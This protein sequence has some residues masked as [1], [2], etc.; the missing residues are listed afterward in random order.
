MVFACLMSRFPFIH[1]RHAKVNM[2][3]RAPE[4]PITGTRPELP[5]SRGKVFIVSP[6]CDAQEEFGAL[7]GGVISVSRI[8]RLAGDMRLPPGRSRDWI[9]VRKSCEW[10]PHRP[11]HPERT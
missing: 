11:R 9:I 8:N 5:P 2:D 1:L 3:G 10:W 6:G 4:N 7:Q